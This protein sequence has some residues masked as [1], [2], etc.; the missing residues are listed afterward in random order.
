MNVDGA[1]K[2][3]WRSYSRFSSVPVGAVAGVDGLFI[4]RHLKGA[5]FL[6]GAIPVASSAP[7]YSAFGAMDV[8]INDRETEQV[9]NGEVSTKASTSTG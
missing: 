8:I 9:Y 1:A 7:G 5:K 3:D 2:L 6:P 4:G